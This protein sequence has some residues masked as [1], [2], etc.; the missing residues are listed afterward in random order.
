MHFPTRDPNRLGRIDVRRTRAFTRLGALVVAGAVAAA[1]LFVPEMRSP[2]VAA[3]GD[4][5]RLVVIGDSLLAGFASGGLVRRGRMGQRDSAP[6]LIARQA[7]VKLRQPLMSR[8]GFPPPL[9]IDDRNKNGILDPGE[10]RRRQGDVGFRAKPNQE[11]RNLAVP[12]ER[13]SSVFEA[14]DVED[15]V[16]DAIDGD[17]RGRDIMKL[18]ILGLPLRDD[19]VS[20]VS[21]AR[22]L[23]PSTL[24][25]WLGNNDVLG[26]ATRTNPEGVPDPVVFGTQFRRLLNALADTGAPMV[27]ANLPD[28][29]GVAALRRAAGEVTTC[30]QGGTVLPVAADDLLPITL[31]RSLLP[32]PPCNRVLDSAEGAFV[33]DVVQ[34]VNVEIASAV[35]DVEVNRGVPI[36]LVDVFG[37]FDDI[38]R[39]GYDVRGDGSVVLTSR[40][41]GGIFT[42]DGIHPTRTAHALIA[43]AFIDAMNAKFAT[44]VPRVD[45]AGIAARD[46]FVGHRFTPAG[47]PPFGVIAEDDVDAL[48]AGLEFVEDHADEIAEQLVDRFEDLF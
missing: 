31:D 48:D 25:V 15:A 46:R 38:R 6:A 21:R 20:Q 40:Y 10:V 24:L 39:N 4:L 33:R 2:A 42:L 1:S 34:A 3:T 27:V 19:A 44:A 8:P 9:A 28:V 35:A 16:G 7:G 41:L 12:G 45:V 47:E 22:N 13:L 32:E 14:I 29:T 23:Q 30:R 43:N 18:V 5:S 11:V 36:A 37:L 26:A 17:L